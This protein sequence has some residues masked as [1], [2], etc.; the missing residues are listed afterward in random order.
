MAREVIADIDFDN[1]G[2]VR[3]RGLEGDLGGLQSQTEKTANVFTHRMFNMRTAAMAFLGGFTVAGAI[4]VFKGFVED[5]AQG[6]KH[7]KELAASGKVFYE[8]ILGIVKDSPILSALFENIGK[9]IIIAASQLKVMATHWKEFFTGA[10]GDKEFSRMVDE[11][12]QKLI[13]R[14]NELMA[15]VK[16]Q[17]LTV[18]TASWAEFNDAGKDAWKTWTNFRDLMNENSKIIVEDLAPIIDHL[19]LLQEKL[20]L[21]QE[22]GSAVGQAL[23]QAFLE[24]GESLREALAKVLKQVAMSLFIKAG[25]YFALGLAAL[26]PWGAAT[27][28]PA[29]MYFKAAGAFAAAGAAVGAFGIGVGGRGAAHSGAGGASGQAATAGGPTYNISVYGAV[30]N[31]AAL[32][33]YIREGMRRADRGNG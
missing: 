2:S 12:I 28:G 22:V 31:D 7:F 9:F 19:D 16:P 8:T 20:A 30:G 14:R 18:M 29:P 23:A 24:G 6:N 17:F 25:E 1:T 4:L 11:Q 33:R 27:L 13:K 15:P 3:L 21:V 10:L 26:T 32:M 5:V